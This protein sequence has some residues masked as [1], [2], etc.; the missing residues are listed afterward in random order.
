[1]KSNTED[2]QQEVEFMMKDIFF[3][4]RNK[5]D[6]FYWVLNLEDHPNSFLLDKSFQNFE[7]SSYTE[8]T[9]SLVILQPNV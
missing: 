8:D 7:G 5:K 6:G 9:E 1:M 4:I 2:K 3:I